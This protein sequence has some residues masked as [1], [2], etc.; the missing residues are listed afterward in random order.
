M[1]SRE[2]FR[3]ITDEREREIRD[4]VRVRNLLRDGRPQRPVAHPPR[5][6]PK[7]RS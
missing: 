7:P 2:L 3:A 4:L 6:M 1:F 5:R